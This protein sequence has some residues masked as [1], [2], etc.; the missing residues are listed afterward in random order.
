[1]FGVRMGKNTLLHVKTKKLKQK[2]WNVLI[3]KK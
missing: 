1:M 2:I 3:M